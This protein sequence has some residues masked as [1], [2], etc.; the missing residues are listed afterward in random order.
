[1]NQRLERRFGM[2]LLAKKIKSRTARN[3]QILCAG[4]PHCPNFLSKDLDETSKYQIYWI[5]NGKIRQAPRKLSR[6]AI[7]FK[8]RHRQ[9]FSINAIYRGPPL[10]FPIETPVEEM[11]YTCI[12]KKPETLWQPSPY[13]PQIFPRFPSTGQVQLMHQTHPEK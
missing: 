7:I 9:K 4:S 5:Q 1:M 3:L 6:K 8:L 12:N 10:S 2:K 13:C 11:T